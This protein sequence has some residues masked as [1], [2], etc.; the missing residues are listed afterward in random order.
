MASDPR[1]IIKNICPALFG[2]TALD[3]FIQMAVELTDRSFFGKLAPYAIAYRACHLFT[4]TGGG[5]SG[6]AA[7][8]MGQIASMS[9]GGLSV[10]FAQ[11]QSKDSSG[12]GL[13]T[14]KYGILL[15]GLIKSR[16]TMG[17]NTAGLHV[18]R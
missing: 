5:G 16:P 4:I 11:S 18:P 9:E 15:L 12:S 3:D 13:E 8:G 17:V 6:N 14:T 1:Q 2:S 7:L 10:T